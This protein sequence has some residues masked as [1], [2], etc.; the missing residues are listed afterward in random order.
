MSNHVF[1]HSEIDLEFDSKLQKAVPLTVEREKPMKAA[2]KEWKRLIFITILI[3]IVAVILD[4]AWLIFATINFSIHHVDINL[5]NTDLSSESLSFFTKTPKSSFFFSWNV[6]ESSFCSVIDSIEDREILHMQPNKVLLTSGGLTQVKMDIIPTDIRGIEDLQSSGKRLVCGMNIPVTFKPTNTFLFKHEVT[7]NIGTDGLETIATNNNSV[8]VEEQSKKTQ[9]QAQPEMPSMDIGKVKWGWK[10]MFPSEDKVENFVGYYTITVPDIIA[11]LSIEKKQ[12]NDEYLESVEA[13]PSKVKLTLNEFS[14]D[15]RDDFF[16]VGVDVECISVEHGKSCSLLHPS[17]DSFKELMNNHEVTGDIKY[18]TD[19]Q[20]INTVLAHEKKKVVMGL[21]YRKLARSQRLA[22]QSSWN[23]DGAEFSGIYFDYW[24][25][26][27]CDFY[28]YPPS[29]EGISLEVPFFGFFVFYADGQKTNTF[30]VQGP[31]DDDD[32]NSFMGTLVASTTFEKAMNMKNTYS[33]SMTGIY[34]EDGFEQI[35]GQGIHALSYDHNITGNIYLSWDNDED[36]FS[37]NVD[38]DIIVFDASDKDDKKFAWALTVD[39]GC[40][41]SHKC[42]FIADQYLMVGG[43]IVNDVV[44][45]FGF[46]Y[47]KNDV[48]NFGFDYNKNDLLFINAIAGG[49]EG[50]ILDKSFGFQGNLT[51]NCLDGPDCDVRAGLY[52]MWDNFQYLNMIFNTYY[53][54]EAENN[55]GEM[56]VDLINYDDNGDISVEISA[57]AGWENP[58]I[59]ALSFSLSSKFTVYGMDYFDITWSI[60][61]QNQDN[62]IMSIQTYLSEKITPAELFAGVKYNDTSMDGNLDG[63]VD[64]FANGGFAENNDVWGNSI[65]LIVSGE[66]VDSLKVDG[67]WKM[68]EVME[69]FGQDNAQTFSGKMS[70][71]MQHLSS[72]DFDQ[73]HNMVIK[74]ELNASVATY[75]AEY[76]HGVDTMDNYANLLANWFSADDMELMI[77]NSGMVQSMNFDAWID[78]KD[79]YVKPFVNFYDSTG[80]FMWLIAYGVYASGVYHFIPLPSISLPDISLPDIDVDV[81]AISDLPSISLSDISLPDIDVDVGAMSDYMTMSMDVGFQPVLNPF[82]VKKTGDKIDVSFQIQSLDEEAYLKDP[83]KTLGVIKNAIIEI[84]PKGYVPANILEIIVKFISKN[85]MRMTEIKDTDVTYTL[86]IKG[87][88]NLESIKTKTEEGINSGKFTTELKASA[89]TAGLEREFQNIQ[90]DASSVTVTPENS[91]SPTASPTSASVASDSSNS[92]DGLGLMAIIGIVIGAFA[93]IGV[94]IGVVYISQVKNVGKVDVSY[95]PQVQLADPNPEN[96]GEMNDSQ[97]VDVQHTPQVQL[98]V[99]G[100][101]NMGEMNL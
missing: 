7:T 64:I 34:A 37:S 69:I 26:N 1:E 52:I 29:D 55:S 100:Q 68:N 72:S 19:S 97:K 95:T 8:E 94:G 80:D 4:A 56:G 61:Y 86:A 75:I 24:S 98:T 28:Y 48:V 99:P 9:F 15:S 91:Q 18:S 16:H 63:V 82:A 44:V 31:Y 50:A 14:T 38:V 60:S 33:I 27:Y 62:K 25:S 49:V 59:D 2:R 66:D 67:I 13:Y 54:T 87:E 77:E 70:F 88:D 101:E 92:D 20:I 53:G 30:V 65:Q 10:I 71:T 39:Q 42:N 96:M 6:A 36:R 43:K 57:G 17:V 51:H 41:T 85:R 76:T 35:A 90:V 84:L 74:G 21:N 11:E 73:E 81:R 78:S 79:G 22:D 45:N 58:N 23:C 93:L 32:G 83:E 40:Q 5:T 3:V 47:N 46:D 89:K 12:S